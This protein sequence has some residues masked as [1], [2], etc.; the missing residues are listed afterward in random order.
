MN[1]H[2][3]WLV[4]VTKLVLFLAMVLL[5]CLLRNGTKITSRF[6]P[7][8]AFEDTARSREVISDGW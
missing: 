1:H 3:V 7:S 2:F 5:G 6:L 8:V 4:L